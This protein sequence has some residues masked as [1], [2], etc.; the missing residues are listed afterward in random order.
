MLICLGHLIEKDHWTRIHF[1]FLFRPRLRVVI[2]LNADIP[3]RLLI[4]SFTSLIV[5]ITHWRSF[6]EVVHKWM[7]YLANLHFNWIFSS[8]KGRKWGRRGLGEGSLSVVEN[9]CKMFSIEGGRTT[10]P[11]TQIDCV[12]NPIKR[13]LM[14]ATSAT[15]NNVRHDARCR[16]CTTLH[17]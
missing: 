1:K 13:I 10:T 2:I 3:C 15:M 5:E 7:H 16:Q 9:S 4:T 17:Q 14:T 12:L 8:D 11:T 6:G